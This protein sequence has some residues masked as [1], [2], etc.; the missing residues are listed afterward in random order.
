MELLNVTTKVTKI[1]FFNIIVFSLLMIVPGIA[2]N[3][4]ITE[5]I[6]LAS[7]NVKSDIKGSFVLGFG[8]VERQGYYAAYRINKDG[9]K[10]Y[11]KM[12]ME[13]TKIYDTLEPDESAYAIVK[14][15]KNAL[16]TDIIEIKLY[17]PKD[18][19]QKQ[20]DLSLEE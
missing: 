15:N 8:E 5:R 9:S 17:V 11:Y 13:M 10:S 12:D 6:E 1:M 20:I 4:Q 16:G 7:I 19:I 3:T 2:Q 14:K 18:T